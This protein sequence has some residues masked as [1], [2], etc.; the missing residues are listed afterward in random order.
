MRTLQIA[1]S[2]CGLLPQAGQLA[3]ACSTST[4]LPFANAVSPSWRDWRRPLPSR[5]RRLPPFSTPCYPSEDRSRHSY[6]LR[7]LRSVVVC[8]LAS[9]F[10][11]RT[12]VSVSGA[13]I[14]PSRCRAG[15]P[16]PNTSRSPLIVVQQA[17]EPRTPPDRALALPQRAPID[18][19]ILES[20]VIPFAMVVIDEF[21]EGAAKVALTEGRLVGHYGIEASWKGGEGNRGR[22]PYNRE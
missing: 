2:R 22:T 9:S 21:L 3:W 1:V 17:A 4:Y 5:W 15:A 18:K 8:Q 14:V 11:N 16:C 6:R 20:L 7:R 19:P 12:R 13:R 10:S